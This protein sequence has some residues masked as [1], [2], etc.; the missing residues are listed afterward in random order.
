MPSNLRNEA[1][2]KTSLPEAPLRRQGAVSYMRNEYLRLH[3]LF[4]YRTQPVYCL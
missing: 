1:A 4:K 3:A 2:E